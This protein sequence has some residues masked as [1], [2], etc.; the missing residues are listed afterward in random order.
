VAHPH[1]STQESQYTVHVN[2]LTTPVEMLK[3]V[4][5]TLKIEMLDPYRECPIVNRPA[6]FTNHRRRRDTSGQGQKKNFHF[7]FDLT[8]ANLWF[9]FAERTST[10]ELIDIGMFPFVESGVVGT[11]LT[12]WTGE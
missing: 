11:R 8:I 9:P 6:C 4:T 5:E 7:Q 10:W 12:R 1:H 3:Q 2:R